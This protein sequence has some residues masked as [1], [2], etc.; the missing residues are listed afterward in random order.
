FDVLPYST[1]VRYI[2]VVRDGRD[3]VRSEY[4]TFHHL[5]RSR[6]TASNSEAGAREFFLRWLQKPGGELLFFPHVR[7]WWEARH[8]PNVKLVHYNALKRDLHAEI[9]GI[10][11]FL[12]VDPGGLPIEDIVE[13][14]SFDYMKANAA[15]LLPGQEAHLPGVGD[16]M[17]FKGENDRWR[18]S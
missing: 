1:D 5:A 15:V 8:L 17:I 13:R 12:G 7:S 18:D 9:S 4:D 14:C 11:T 2:N 10:A 16:Y 3:V 6:R